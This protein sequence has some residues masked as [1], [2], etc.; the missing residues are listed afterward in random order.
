MSDLKIFTDHIQPNA[1]LL[2]QTA[3]AMRTTAKRF[4]K[5]QLRQNL[6]CNGEFTCENATNVL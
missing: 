1:A 2:V 4:L 6:L 3:N 5:F